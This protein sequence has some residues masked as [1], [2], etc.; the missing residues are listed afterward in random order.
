MNFNLFFLLVLINIL[1]VLI[2]IMI[3]FLFVSVIV[4]CT[5]NHLIYLNPS[6]LLSLRIHHIYIYGFLNKREEIVTIKEEN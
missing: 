6:M 4:T 1:R 5:S 3:F 2:L